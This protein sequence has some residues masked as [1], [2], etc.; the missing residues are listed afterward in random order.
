MVGICKYANIIIV[1]HSENLFQSTH[2]GES[3]YLPFAIKLKSGL[4]DKT[5]SQRFHRTCY[6]DNSF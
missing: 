5:G 4:K 6:V 2:P 1:L 3:A